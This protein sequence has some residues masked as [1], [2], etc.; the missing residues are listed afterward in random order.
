VTSF[1]G[2]DGDGNGIVEQA[3]LTVW[4]SHYGQTFPGSGSG[5]VMAHVAAGSGAEAQSVQVSEPVPVTA[6]ARPVSTEQAPVSTQVASDVSVAT[7]RDSA[8]LSVGS[9]QV[10]EIVGVNTVIEH[11][12]TVLERTS[13][14]TPPSDLGLLAWLAASSVGERPQADL[15]SLT[16]KDFSASVASDEPESVDVAFEL[17]EGNALALATI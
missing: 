5:S 7:T 10:F 6:A 15:T 3:D 4:R 1:S 9:M 13:E 11:D 14:S 17:L 2:A 8:K 16:D 12:A